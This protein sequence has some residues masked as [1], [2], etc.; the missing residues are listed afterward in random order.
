M[1]KLQSSWCRF[2]CFWVF[3][4]QFHQKRRGS[5]YRFPINYK[6]TRW[7]PKKLNVNKNHIY[8]LKCNQFSDLYVF[9]YANSNFTCNL[10]LSLNRKWPKSKMAANNY[11]CYLKSHIKCQNQSFWCLFVCVWV[12][13]F[14]I[15]QT[16]RVISFCF[17]INDQNPRWPPT[18][19]K[20]I[21][22]SNF[23]IFVSIYM[24]L[25]MLI[26]NSLISKRLLL[27][28]S[29]KRQKSKMAAKQIFKVI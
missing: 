23:I 19:I 22:I 1:V 12:C 5:L 4:I 7:P 6:H 25:G 28:F 29:L 16:P 14:Q 26:S 8:Q 18:S 21:Y 17:P 11:R 10:V 27:L 24:F 20:K 13:K 15:H 9:R 2:I 3:L